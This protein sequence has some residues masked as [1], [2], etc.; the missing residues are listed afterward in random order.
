M[1]IRSLGRGV[2]ASSGSFATGLS[3]EWSKGVSSSVMVSKERGAKE[4]LKLR[5]AGFTRSSKTC[6]TLHIL[7]R[8]A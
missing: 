1:P 7:G 2:M 3:A 8:D 5:L 4:I 6:W